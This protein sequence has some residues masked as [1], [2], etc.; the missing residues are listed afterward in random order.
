MVTQRS[1]RQLIHFKKFIS[2]LSST[3][4]I[5]LEESFLAKKTASL[6]YSH[7]IQREFGENSAGRSPLAN[8]AIGDAHPCS[9]VARI[10]YG[11]LIACLW[12]LLLVIGESLWFLRL[13][14]AAGRCWLD[15]VN[16]LDY[17]L[18][19]GQYAAIIFG[20]CSWS[21]LQPETLLILHKFNS[22]PRERERRTLK[23]G[24]E[25]KL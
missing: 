3:K 15:S 20:I 21:A 19:D 2:N 12:I 14:I 5:F 22:S 24:L 18:A 17:S 10:I 4:V 11:R 8:Q 25:S 13:F 1:N 9:L 7:S 6:C 23:L 16:G